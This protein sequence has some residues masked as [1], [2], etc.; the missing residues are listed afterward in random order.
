MATETTT[1]TSDARIVD[2]LYFEYAEPVEVSDEI[3]R[4]YNTFDIKLKHICSHYLSNIQYTLGKCPRCLGTGYYY[5]AKFNEMGRLVEI[6]LED[7]LQQ[8]LEKLVLTDENKFHTDVAIGLKKW[9]GEVPISEIKAIIKYDLMEGIA[10][11]KSSQ[12]SIAGLSSRAQISSV[13]DIIITVL[14][15]DSLHYVVTI[16]TVSGESTNL[17]GVINFSDITLTD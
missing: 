10:A 3:T 2:P 9:L 13:D 12:K 6:S 17:E 14:D 5:D 8:A 11:L 7:K 15:V 16:T 1:I 4:N